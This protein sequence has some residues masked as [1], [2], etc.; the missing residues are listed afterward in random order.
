MERG[1]GPD[2]AV[3]VWRKAP[4]S[5]L[6]GPSG[7]SK[8]LVDTGQVNRRERGKVKLRVP[9]G[10]SQEKWATHPQGHSLHLK[11][12]LHIKTKEDSRD[13][14]WD[15]EGE[16]G[17]SRGMEEQVFARPGKGPGAGGQ[18]RSLSSHPASL[19]RALSPHWWQ[20]SP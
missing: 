17:N 6:L 2:S 15:I 1:W 7:W 10:E 14:S 11:S 13:D 12:Y 9:M 3:T 19:P 16:E 8:N 18:L 20:M 5:A 4:A